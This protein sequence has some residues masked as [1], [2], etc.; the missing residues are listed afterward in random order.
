ML[1]ISYFCFRCLWSSHALLKMPRHREMQFKMMYAGFKST[2]SALSSHNI[3]ISVKLLKV[4]IV[5]VLFEWPFVNHFW[6]KECKEMKDGSGPGSHSLHSSENISITE[7]QL[8]FTEASWGASF[9]CEESVPLVWIPD[10]APTV[11]QWIQ[12]TVDTSPLE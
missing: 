3:E 9:E 7:P 8:L 5:T 4:L 12:S 1:L 6:V 10:T 11:P 2:S